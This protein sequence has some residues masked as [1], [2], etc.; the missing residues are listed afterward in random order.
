MI[1]TAE[2]VDQIMVVAVRDRSEL[3]P[4]IKA[5]MKKLTVSSGTASAY[6]SAWLRANPAAFPKYRPYKTREAS[7]NH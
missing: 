1:R 7:N 3:P 4:S 2:A 6:R 5:I